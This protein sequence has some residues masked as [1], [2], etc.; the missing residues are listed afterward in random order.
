ME[1]AVVL[2]K[3]GL[4]TGGSRNLSIRSSMGMKGQLR[5]VGVAPV[6]TIAT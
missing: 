5:G 1:M 6:G 2:G 3:E 4:G